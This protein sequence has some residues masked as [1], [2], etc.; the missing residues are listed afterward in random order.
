MFMTK[1]VIANLMR[2]SST[3]L[4]PAEVREPFKGF[5]G[6][7][8]NDINVCIFCKKCQ[9]VCPSQ[10]IKVD[11]KARTWECDPFACVY[12]GICV[13]HCPVASLSMR[14]TYRPVSAEREMIN[15]QGPPKVA[16][17]K[18]GEKKEKEEE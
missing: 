15:L 2:K 16:K 13:D 17:A 3:R 1:N 6:M 4:Y 11:L 7:L 5:R 18:A 8:E 10:C 9:L 12:C 14:A